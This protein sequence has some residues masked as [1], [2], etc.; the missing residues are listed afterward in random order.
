MKKILFL[1]LFLFSSLIIS[2]QC[3][4]TLTFGGAHTIGQ[5]PNGALWG[6]GAASYGNLLTSN[7]SE[8][9][10]IQLGTETDWNVIENGTINTFSKK[11][12]GTLWG[13][14]SNQF[15]SLGVNSTIQNFSSFQQITTANDWAESFT[16]LFFY[17]ST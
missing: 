7:I 11:K 12:D 5:K 16:F 14:G 10:P 9:N 2:A 3:F 4:E 15:G 1:K 6:W 17:T 13:C 8:P